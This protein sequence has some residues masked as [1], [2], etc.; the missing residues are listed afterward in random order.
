MLHVVHWNSN[1]TYESVYVNVFVLWG[2]M[3]V[4]WEEVPPIHPC[5]V[6]VRRCVN[7]C[8]V[9][10]PGLDR[11]LGNLWGMLW[12]DMR[13]ALED[14]PLNPAFV[15]AQKRALGGNLL[16]P[17]EVCKQGVCIHTYCGRFWGTFWGICSMLFVFSFSSVGVTYRQDSWREGWLSIILTYRVWNTTSVS[18]CVTKNTYLCYPLLLRLCARYQWVLECKATLLMHWLRRK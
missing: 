1:M 12:G 9:Y 13:V 8:F 14:V 3:Q 2:S 17:E 10:T 5:W 16:G 18:V 15:G 6:G 7:R 11:C 4:S